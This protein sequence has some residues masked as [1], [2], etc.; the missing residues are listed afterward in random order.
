MH[1]E[2]GLILPHSINVNQLEEILKHGS[3][4]IVGNV[5]FSIYFCIF[6]GFKESNQAI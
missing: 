6:I 4:E 3:S 2:E 1:D 5:Y